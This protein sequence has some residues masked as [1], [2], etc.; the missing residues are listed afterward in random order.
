MNKKFSA[1]VEFIVD[2]NKLKSEEEKMRWRLGF[3]SG[4]DPRSLGGEQVSNS[5]LTAGLC[6][7]MRV[8]RGQ[9]VSY[10]NVGVELGKLSAKTLSETYYRINLGFT[11]NDNSWFLKRKFQ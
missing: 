3:R 1:G 9:Q 8:G 10:L 5:A 6:L 2:K 7:P 4:N 11:L